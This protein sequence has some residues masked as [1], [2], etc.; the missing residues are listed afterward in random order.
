MRIINTVFYRYSEFEGSVRRCPGQI[1]AWLEDTRIGQT[2][3]VDRP[4]SFALLTLLRLREDLAYYLP[5][6]EY[7]HN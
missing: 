4:R 5:D 1:S 7:V 6:R 3:A 2:V